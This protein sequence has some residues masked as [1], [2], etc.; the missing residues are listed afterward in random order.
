MQ[1]C[2]VDLIPLFKSTVLSSSND[3]R[4][5]IDDTLT[6]CKDAAFRL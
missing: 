6:N 4:V 1:C 2:S 5:V 3:F